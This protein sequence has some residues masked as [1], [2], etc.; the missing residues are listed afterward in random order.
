MEFTAC[1]KN[2][3]NQWFQSEL[4]RQRLIYRGMGKE[5]VMVLMRLG[6]GHRLDS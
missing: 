4:N 1:G 6:A 3:M 5:K 2:S